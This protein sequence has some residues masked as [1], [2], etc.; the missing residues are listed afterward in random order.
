MSE[1]YNL[2]V[3]TAL[4]TLAIK[5]F[6]R[7]GISLLLNKI[8]ISRRTMIYGLLVALGV[9]FLLSFKLIILFLPLTDFKSKLFKIIM[10]LSHILR[11]IW[12]LLQA[13]SSLHVDHSKCKIC[14]LILYDLCLLIKVLRVRL[15]PLRAKIAH[16]YPLGLPTET[17]RSVGSWRFQM[18]RNDLLAIIYTASTVLN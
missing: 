4:S 17:L 5:S 13:F 16:K 11:Y 8:L 12:K 10:C 3:Y 15:M 6:G 2:K 9:N 1:R 7:R 14:G 18:R